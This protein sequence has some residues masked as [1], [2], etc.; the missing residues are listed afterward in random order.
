MQRH[1]QRFHLLFK[2]DSEDCVYAVRPLRPAVVKHEVVVRRFDPAADKLFFR[3]DNFFLTARIVQGDPFGFPYVDMVVKIDDFARLCIDL[4]AV[5]IRGRV[6]FQHPAGAALI[7]AQFL[8]GENHFFGKIGISKTGIFQG[9]GSC[10]FQGYK[11][12]HFI[13]GE[14]IAVDCV[15]TVSPLRMG[16]VKYKTIVRIFVAFINQS[17]L[18]KGN[19]C[20]T[21]GVVQ[22]NGFRLQNAYVLCV[23]NHGVDFFLQAYQLIQRQLGK[24]FF[25]QTTVS[26]RVTDELRLSLRNAVFFRKGCR[27]GVIRFGHINQ[28]MHGGFFFKHLTHILRHGLFELFIFV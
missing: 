3:K 2:N 10:F 28:G 24:S 14:Y 9:N 16:V 11:Q 19:S 25:C 21:A 5:L 1:E 12:R 22:G 6:K 17:C 20:R 13:F 4:V 26:H 23:D 8:F 27:V 15:D 7:A 18:G